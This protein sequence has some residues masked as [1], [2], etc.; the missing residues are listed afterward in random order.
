MIWICILR[1]LLC[2]TRLHRE[3]SNGLTELRDNPTSPNQQ[4]TVVGDS[5]SSPSTIANPLNK[6]H[7][8]RVP[9]SGIDPGTGQKQQQNQS[10]SNPSNH[11]NRNRGMSEGQEKLEHTHGQTQDQK[12]PE[13]SKA[14]K[15]VLQRVRRMIPPMLPSFHKG[16]SI[17]PATIGA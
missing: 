10:T 6:L 11:G 13:M 3:G 15:Q 4:R 9:A 1:K 2:S 5:N 12:Q 7:I 14:T 8:P 16:T 17:N